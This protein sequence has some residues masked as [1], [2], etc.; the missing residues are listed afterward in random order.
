[1]TAGVYL[2]RAENGLTKVGHSSNVEH[3]LQGLV[4]G[5][6]IILTL[7]HVIETDRHKEIEHVLHQRFAA[8]RRHGEWFELSDD[9]ITAITEY[10]AMVMIAISAP[11]RRPVPSFTAT[12]EPASTRAPRRRVTRNPGEPSQDLLQDA[13]GHWVKAQHGEDTEGAVQWF[14][15]TQ[16][17]LQAIN[18]HSAA[19][20][21][22]KTP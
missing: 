22:A 21:R 13:M 4:T 19:E 3:R 8:Q 11:M 5:S 12:A 15:I 1:M 10:G 9:D 7:S 17:L 18:Q 14:E 2:V 6:P 20:P 16:G